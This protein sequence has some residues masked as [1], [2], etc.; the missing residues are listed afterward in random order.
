LAVSAQA[1]A[2]H[3]PM[4]GQT[5]SAML[6]SCDDWYFDHLSPAGPFPPKTRQV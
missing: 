2:V 5:Y 4:S 1:A 3:P 6:L